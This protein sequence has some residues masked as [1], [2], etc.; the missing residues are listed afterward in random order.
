MSKPF[1][2]VIDCKDV[3]I[4]HFGEGL[5]SKQGALVQHYKDTTVNFEDGLVEEEIDKFNN[6]NNVKLNNFVDLLNLNAFRFTLKT[7]KLVQKPG[8]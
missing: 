6:K 3:I 1:L 4:N 7:Q 2:V 8:H 5:T